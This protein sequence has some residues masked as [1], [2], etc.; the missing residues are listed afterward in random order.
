DGLPHLEKWLHRVAARPA[1]KRGLDVP[2]KSTLLE[3]KFEL[4]ADADK[5]AAESREWILKGNG[6]A[7][8]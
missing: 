7:P 2:E 5:K 8:K 6:Q 1:V 4:E 3:R